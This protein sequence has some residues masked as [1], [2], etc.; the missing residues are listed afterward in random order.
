[1]CGIV[2]FIGE[3]IK[4]KIITGALKKL[5]YRGYDSWGV[6]FLSGKKIT[7]FKAVGEIN[8]IPKKIQEIKSGLAIGHTRWATHGKINEVNAHPHVSAGN[9]LTLVH[10]GIIENFSE[11]KKE[12]CSHNFCS[13]T[14]SEVVLHLIE[15]NLSKGMDLLHSVSKS[16][17]VLKGSFSLLVF[18]SDEPDKLIAV[19]NES[20]LL[21]GI[22]D[23][24]IFAASDQI[25]LSSFTDKFVFLEDK[26]IAL[27]SKNKFQC[28]DFDLN[29]V[30][31][32]ILK[33][34]SDVTSSG[35]LKYSHF[36]LKEIM[37]QPFVLRNA[38]EQEKKIFN[39]IFL[40]MKNSSVFFIANGTSFNAS[41]FG[42][43]FFSRIS[44]IFPQVIDAS[45]FPY[46]VD[47]LPKNSLIFALSQSGETADVL[48]SVKK[49]KKKG[50]KIVSM[51]NVFNSSL[52]RASDK[53]IYLNC[54]EEIGVASTKAFTSQIALLY[55]L[56]SSCAGKFDSA[57]TELKKVFLKM[58]QS[59]EL[60]KN[61]IKFLSEKF[62]SV[63][64]VY[65]IGRSLNYPL[66]LEAA[67]KLKEISYIHA[68]AF[69]AGSLKHGPLAL[70]SDG[71][72][73]IVVAPKDSVFSDTINNAIEAKSRGAFIVGIGD[74]ENPVFDFFI[75]IPKVKE[76]LFPLILIP[77][78]QLLAFHTAVFL[79]RNPDK[80]RNL[81]KVCTVK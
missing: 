51:V 2:G 16:V 64:D 62:K 40:M 70:I 49:A 56:A 60:N 5:E 9:K 11:L 71:V 18:S 37:E 24:G 35:K 77:P 48:D 41:L 21:L 73:V 33:V 1:M 12:L 61:S 78:L 4:G 6:A 20:P 39:E 42:K 75:K 43:E 17:S 47:F 29:K 63:K 38:L 13:E 52:A 68:E 22:S 45:E 80:P 19:K 10:N 44:G 25:P 46:Q 55:L 66:A 79:E 81:A 69:P 27:I 50:F 74:E 72:P 7:F 53:V 31:R 57:L 28:F 67:L 36:M 26:D 58:Q 23:K 15:E 14:D 54:G 34:K 59:I 3:P 76:L 8:G 30:E 32:K 65:F